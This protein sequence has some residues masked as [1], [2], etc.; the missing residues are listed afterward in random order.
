MVGN[1]WRVGGIVGLGVALAAV[2]TFAVTGPTPAADHDDV[3]RAAVATAS[4]VVVPPGPAP[5]VAA[6][7]RARAS[8]APATVPGWRTVSSSL[9]PSGHADQGVAVIIGPTGPPLVVTR[10]SGDIPATLRQAGWTHVGDPDAHRGVLFDAYQSHPGAGRKMFLVTLPDHRQIQLVHPLVPTELVNNSFA[11][12][13]PDGRWLV[14][15]EWGT[16]R[17]FLVFALP[18]LYPPV[19]TLDLPLATTIV[20]THPV[21]DV[22][23]CSFASATSLLCATNDPGLD[24]FRTPRQLLR[25]DL[26]RALDGHV[27]AGTPTWLA[28]APQVS[29]CAGAGEVEG[30]DDTDGVVRLVV[31]QP[32]ACRPATRLWTWTT[33]P[34]SA[35]ALA[36]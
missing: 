10:G 24:L 17:R 34:A 16:M 19:P 2:T 36:G 3:V 14:S 32:G 18:R 31:V 22:Q 23:G 26:T 27:V 6:A 8:T 35:A 4:V 33:G 28:A 11:A 12:V 15:G 25:V 13:S 21:R 29:S 9:R 5:T 7:P 20:L 30:I 1:G